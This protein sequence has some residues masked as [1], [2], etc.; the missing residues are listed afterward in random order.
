M[1][2][3]MAGTPRYA[4]IAVHAGLPN[5]MRDDLE[6]FGYMLIYFLKGSLPWYENMKLEFVLNILGKASVESMLNFGGSKLP[7]LRSTCPRSSLPT[8]YQRSSRFTS[9]IVDR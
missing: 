8:A 9:T 4:S 1:L 5:S 6:A 3:K 7:K 2:Q